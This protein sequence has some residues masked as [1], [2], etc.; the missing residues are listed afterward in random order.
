MIKWPIYLLSL[1]FCEPAVSQQSIV[2]HGI[3][4]DSITGTPLVAANIRLLGTAKGTITNTQGHYSLT[5]EP[6]T[7][8]IMFSYLAYQPETLTTV[9]Q[10]S[11]VHDVALLQSPI[12][13]PEVVVLAE[14][15]ALEIIR[16]AIAYKRRWMEKISSYQFDAFTRQVLRRD[17]AIASI[18]EAYTT[19]FWRTGDTLRE[20]IRQKR[21][22]ENIPSAENF[23][24]VRRI[25]N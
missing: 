7:Y 14:D 5:V 17:T 13:I 3:I 15:P 16:K 10:H 8:S 23:A 19:G 9:L 18:T 1:L 24:A 6:G 11:M 22:T 25:V 2:L 20:I 4:I 12:Q 21:Q